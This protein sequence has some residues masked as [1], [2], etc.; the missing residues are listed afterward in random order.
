MKHVYF[1]R[2]GQTIANRKSIH[3]GPDEPLSLD[4]RRQAER[5]GLFMKGRDID[6]LV[7]STYVRARETAEL[8][9]KEL[10][11]PYTIHESVREFGRPKYLYNK[12]HYT[13]SSLVYIWRLFVHRDD[14]LWDDH[15]AEN[16][17]SVRNRVLDA[18]AMVASLEGE[19]IVVVSHAIFM[20]MFI[21]LA[22]REKKLTLMQFVGSLLN[23]KKTP[24]TGILHTFYDENAPKG[25]CKWQLVEFLDPRTDSPLA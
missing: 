10:G 9:G 20:D 25:V 21:E 12:G 14:P 6:T 3:Q 22:C 13:L 7:C 11:L 24:N 16:M 18:K 1:I 2:H 4:G 5:V 8:I 17:F 15:G 19:R 23:I